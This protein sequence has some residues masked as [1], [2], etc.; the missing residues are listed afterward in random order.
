M[1][2]IALEIEVSSQKVCGDIT[3]VEP[4]GI[5]VAIVSPY[6]GF[7]QSMHV[8]YFAMGADGV[9]MHKDRQMTAHGEEIA[10]QL[11]REIYEIVSI[12]ERHKG[13][14]K[15]RYSVLDDAAFP[16]Q[17]RLQMLSN[18][19]ETKFNIGVGVDLLEQLIVRYCQE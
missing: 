5:T 19:L 3:H 18:Y 10:R 12:F 11:L 4:N 1:T 9:R 15:T 13:E 8:P 7:T 16:E 6:Q 14:I 2:H 17:N